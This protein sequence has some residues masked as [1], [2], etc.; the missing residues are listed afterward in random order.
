MQCG[1]R[2]VT[3]A[4]N[5]WSFHW[6]YCMQFFAVDTICGINYTWTDWMWHSCRNKLRK[7]YSALPTSCQRRCNLVKCNSSQYF[8]KWWHMTNI[9][10]RYRKDVGYSIE[11]LHNSLHSINILTHW[12]WQE[13]NWTELNKFINLFFSSSLT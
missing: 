12:M 10:D 13:I 7:N 8:R 2:W 3:L 1:E 4:A 5:N 11:Q 9:A 6:A